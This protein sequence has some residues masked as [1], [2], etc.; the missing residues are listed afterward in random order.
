MNTF[1]SMFYFLLIEIINLP[2]IFQTGTCRKSLKEVG[3]I[4]KSLKIMWNQQ[5]KSAVQLCLLILFCFSI[6]SSF[7][8]E[9]QGKKV[10][11]VKTATFNL[12]ELAKVPDVQTD[13]IKKKKLQNKEPIP[14]NL[15]LPP[16]AIIKR[17]D[18]PN[19]ADTTK[20]EI[21]KK[22]KDNADTIQPN[23]PGL[24]DNNTSIPPDVGGAAGPN[25]LMVTLNT[26]VRV[27]DKSGVTISTVGLD[28]FFS[29]LGE[30]LICLTQKYYMILLKSDG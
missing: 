24:G 17:H 11:P 8:Q 14:G 27:Q 30:P 16:G 7:G 3:V 9:N 19:E 28:A 12:R 2:K 13:T 15:V 10:R 20:F 4:H 5:L 25:H 21:K 18:P 23:F 22:T 1:D 6:T 26:Q 29:S